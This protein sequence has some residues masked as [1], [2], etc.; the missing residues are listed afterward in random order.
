MKEDIGKNTIK[1]A[2]IKIKYFLY[3][4]DIPNI[5]EQRMKLSFIAPD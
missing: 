3:I 5:V 2:K 1:L 4:S